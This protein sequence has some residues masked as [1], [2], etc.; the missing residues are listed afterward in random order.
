MQLL[1]Y[2]GYTG[3]VEQGN[4][5]DGNPPYYGTVQY[6]KDVICYDGNDIDE[7]L[8]SFKGSIDDYIDWCADIK[9]TAEKP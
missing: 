4:N 9:I 5:E 1:Y 3:S 2:K 6:I 8:E 7:L